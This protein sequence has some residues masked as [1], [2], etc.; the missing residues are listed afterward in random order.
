MAG[1][2]AG[3]IPTVDEVKEIAALADP[4]LRNLLITQCYHHLALSITPRTGM[5]ANWCTFATWASKQAGRTIRGEDL[6]QALG[7]SAHLPPFALQPV[8]QTVAQALAFGSRRAP[9]EIRTVLADLLDPL[10][11]IRRASDAV[12]RGNQKVFAEIGYEFARFAAMCL[13]DSTPMQENIDR[14]CSELCPGEPPDGQRY[15]RQAFARYYQ[16]FFEKDAKTRAELMLLAN[17]EIGLH[18]QTRLQ[19]E[20]VE[21]MDA[22]FIDHEEFRQY[23]IGTLFPYRGWFARLRLFLLRLMGRPTPLDAAIADLWS[24]MRRL[25]RLVITEYLL[26]I[27]LPH[28]VRLRLGADLTTPYPPSLTQLVLTDLQSLLAELDP[29]P[30]GLRESGTVDWGNLPDRLHFIIEMF[31]CYQESLSLFDSPY[32]AEQVA[33]IQSGRVPIGPL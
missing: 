33:V 21:A 30:D 15:L 10:A 17:I 22:V 29:T 11:A 2:G 32:T 8:R 6:S 5:V 4:I 27:G 25:N 1:P 7:Y 14:F 31:R 16:V 20:I 28:G 18:E 24:E 23:L 9:R 19:P 12:A 3:H 13:L 26:S